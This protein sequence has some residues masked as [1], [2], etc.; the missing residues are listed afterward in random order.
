MLQVG[1]EKYFHIFDV[2]AIKLKTHH[3][4][5]VETG[6]TYVVVPGYLLTFIHEM[7]CNVKM[8]CYAK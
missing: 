4:R 8:K 7:L 1:V 3:S 5:K 2:N 6:K